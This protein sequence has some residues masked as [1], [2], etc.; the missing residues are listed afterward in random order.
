MSTGPNAVIPAKQPVRRKRSM[1]PDGCFYS[2]RFVFFWNESARVCRSEVE[3][4]G[5]CGGGLIVD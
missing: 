4:P 3:P 5:A 1:N 2:F